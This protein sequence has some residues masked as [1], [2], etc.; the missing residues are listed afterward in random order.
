MMNN[1]PEVF[2]AKLPDNLI[3]HIIMF[4]RHPCADI[5]KQAVEDACNDAHRECASIGRRVVFTRAARNVKNQEYQYN[6]KVM[7]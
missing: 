4:N 1:L 2:I 7:S 5:T 6:E 3:N